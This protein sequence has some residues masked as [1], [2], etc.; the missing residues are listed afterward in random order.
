[1]AKSLPPPIN[2]LLSL[3]LPPDFS[4]SDENT[5][6]YMLKQDTLTWE[7]LVVRICSVS[8]WVSSADM[9]SLPSTCSPSICL[10]PRPIRIQC[11]HS[12]GSISPFRLCLRTFRQ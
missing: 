1:M 5:L 7:N 8:L 3:S 4:R 6:G 11:R 10:H 12:R 9:T 2:N